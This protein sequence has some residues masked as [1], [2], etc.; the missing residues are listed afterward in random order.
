[1]PRERE[2]ERERERDV[3]CPVKDVPRSV[4]WRRLMIAVCT[5]F[6]DFCCRF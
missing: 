4:L 5:D 6:S 3:P 2:R 1:V